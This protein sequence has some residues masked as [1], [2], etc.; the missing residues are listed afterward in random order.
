M[1]KSET[2]FKSV[3]IAHWADVLRLCLGIFADETEAEEAA[4]QTFF[5][6]HNL[7]LFIGLA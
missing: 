5:E 6:A 1:N 3:L 7:L 4:Q 2:E